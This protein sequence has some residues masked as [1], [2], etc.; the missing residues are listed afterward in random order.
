MSLGLQREAPSR[1]IIGFGE[2]ST[3]AF[4]FGTREVSRLP[5]ISKRRHLARRRIVPCFRFFFL[6]GFGLGFAPTVGGPSVPPRTQTTF[7]SIPAFPSPLLNSNPEISNAA[8]GI[9]QMQQQ[10][11]HVITQSERSLKSYEDL[12]E[13][14]SALPY[15]AN[16]ER[17]SPVAITITSNDTGT[18]FSTNPSR[19]HLS[20]RTRSPPWPSRESSSLGI[21]RASDVS[22]S[23]PD[24]SP[25]MLGKQIISSSPLYTHPQRSPDHVNSYFDTQSAG[26]SIPLK[27]P[28]L[29][30]SKRARSPLN[31][32][33]EF[34]EL[35]S[36][37]LD[38]ERE[39]QAKAKRLA[40]F[41]AELNQPLQNLHAL[42]RQKPS[43]NMQNEVPVN[44]QKADEHDEDAQVV[45][46]GIDFSG[47]EGADSLKAVIGLCP[48]MCPESEREERER[49]GDLD[50]FERYD[51]DRNQTSKFLA[52]KKVCAEY[53]QSCL[54]S[55]REAALIRPM[56]VLQK[57]VDYLLNLLDHPYD[58]N[59][60]NI[61]NFLW[62]RMRAVRM[63]LRMQH[64]FNEKAIIMLEQMIRLH[65]IAMHELCEFEK[66]E[67]FTDCFDAHLNIEQMNK[68]SVELF[69]M[70][71][72]HRKQGIY[73]AS[74]KEFRG[75]YALLK[76]D[77]H[78]GYK[79]EPAEL[80]LD[81][82]KMT[83]EIRTTPEILFARDVARACRFGNYIAFF[84]LARKATYLQACLMHAHF[85]K[86]RRQALASLHC[87]LQNNQGIPISHMEK[88]LA[89]EGED[90]EGLLDHH[91]FSTKWYEETYMV[92]EGPFLNTDLDFPTKCA[93]LVYL[94]R[95][96]KV[97]DDVRPV[98]HEQLS[99]EGEYMEVT[100]DE[101]R[102]P[103][104]TEINVVDE[105]VV[106]SKVT[107]PPVVLAEHSKSVDLKDPV[108]L[109][110]QTGM[111][112]PAIP[113]KTTTCASSIGNFDDHELLVDNEKMLYQD[114]EASLSTTTLQVFENNKSQPVN[115]QCSHS[116]M[117]LDT[118]L[119]NN[120]VNERLEN[121]VLEAVFNQ[122]EEATREKLRLILRKWK[123]Q[124]AKR[125]EIREQKEFLAFGA[126]NSLSLGPPVW[127]SEFLI[128]L[129]LVKQQLRS[130]DK[131]DIDAIAKARLVKYENSWSRLKILDWIAP[132][133]VT[134]NP[135]ARMICWKLVLLVQMNDLDNQ[136]LHLASNWLFSKLIGNSKLYDTDAVVSSPDLAI[137]KKQIHSRQTCCLS[138]IRKKFLDDGLQ[139]V[140]ED[141]LVG[142]NCF[143]YLMSQVIS[144]EI[145][146]F[147]LQK[148]LSSLPPGSQLPLLVILVDSQKE[149]G[150]TEKDIVERLALDDTDKRRMLSSVIHLTDNA[151]V[152]YVNGFFN[153]HKLRAGLHWLAEHS[154]PQPSV[155]LIRTRELVLNHLRKIIE[156][157]ENSLDISPYHCISA[158]NK[159][160]DKSAEEIKVSASTNLT[161][162]PAAEV[163]LLERS[164][165]EGVLASQ[166]LPST[167]WSSPASINP[168]VRALE[169]C[170]LPSFPDISWLHSGSH[171]VEQIKQKKVAL[172]DL[173]VGWLNESCKLFKPD[174]AAREANVMVQKGSGLELS[175][176][177]YTI[178][179][180]W[181]SIFRRIYSWQL[182]KLTG[183]EISYCYVL[184]DKNETRDDTSASREFTSCSLFEG[185]WPFHSCQSEVSLDELIDIS[186]ND[187]SKNQ[188]LVFR[189]T[190][191]QQNA[192]QFPRLRNIGDFQY[193]DADAGIT[194]LLD[195]DVSLQLMDAN[196]KTAAPLAPK[197]D[198]LNM[199]LEQCSRL[200]DRIDQQ[201]AIYY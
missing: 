150:I 71:D 188:S 107:S 97:I 108:I 129:I 59:F 64:I 32:V 75:Y 128:C 171:T 153:D 61:Y 88:W 113:T 123:Q 39:M 199:L 148:L 24:K 81:L 142:T 49:K 85:A 40:R 172:E 192:G 94:K 84:R 190:T 173:L 5:R 181:I 29:G 90:V 189:P 67:G 82:A 21:Y 140:E 45:A 80:S 147:R 74:E 117:F 111:K 160:L 125:R 73:V 198:R 4:C 186:F 155:R 96:R 65:I 3:A 9:G 10:Q 163:D 103:L 154:P 115:L 135:D 146:R 182:N 77:K 63:D 33:E 194:N 19:L 86:V 6:F 176:T 132:I 110:Q 2:S 124:S 16:Y 27:S 56:P 106:D 162:W 201:L 83:P 151:P 47:H 169:S 187:S 138:V 100:L 170:K 68:T 58:S 72:D 95:S 99:E 79:V 119:P 37:L 145:H 114:K 184:S 178:V 25:T 157:Y 22:A 109:Y 15:S 104:D 131:L 55:E 23:R 87:G 168:V 43:G 66:G 54:T 69:Q 141:A 183:Q 127:Q 156:V 133:L 44:M 101:Q 175:A 28:Y 137:W 7:G 196:K 116:R 70:Y 53:S 20:K 122:K 159:T 167:G 48:D 166:L 158:F 165:D 18:K 126:L 112:M 92:K 152:Q 62:D 120:F 17:P 191:S 38:S 121:E 200:Q 12:H 134:R 118:A 197:N 1:L 179:P 36:S 26:N 78:P 164:S 50:K 102:K 161:R 105:E 60:L 185:H 143:V 91:G 51:G 136:N 8:T 144:W 98:T 14:P 42:T 46:Y 30:A 57:T 149:E 93:Q 177:G 34:V 13:Q 130:H 195:K 174:L 180:S 76:L 35:S 31:L 193:H 89:M 139:T 41:S 52:V 11:Q